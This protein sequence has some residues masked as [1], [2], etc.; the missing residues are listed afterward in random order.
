MLLSSIRTSLPSG[1]GNVIPATQCCHLTSKVAATEFK[2]TAADGEE[3]GTFLQSKLLFGKRSLSYKAVVLGRGGEVGRLLTEA[4]GQR[5]SVGFTS[6]Q[7]HQPWA[8][9]LMHP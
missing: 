7:S 8:E 5:R 4:H 9:L 3:N 2:E 6:L 1:R